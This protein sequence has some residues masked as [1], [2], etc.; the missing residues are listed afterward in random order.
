MDE[1]KRFLNSINMTYNEELDNTDILKV[2]YNRE[3][4][5]YNVFLHSENVLSY[6]IVNSL[7]L[8]AKNKINGK[9]KL[10]KT[11]NNTLKLV[12]ATLFLELGI[13]ILYIT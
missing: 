4:E 11:L 5:L 3:S 8:A 7:F 9:D 6:D 13:E 12:G 1:L 2:V 10:I